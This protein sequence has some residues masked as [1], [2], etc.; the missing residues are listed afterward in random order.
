MPSCRRPRTTRLI[1]HYDDDDDNDDYDYY[2][3]DYCEQCHART[4]GTKGTPTTGRSAEHL[5]RR[6]GPPTIVPT[7]ITLLVAAVVGL[8]KQCSIVVAQS[9][10]VWGASMFSARARIGQQ[11]PPRGGKQRTSGAEPRRGNPREKTKPADE[12]AEDRATE[13][14]DRM[15]RRRSPDHNFCE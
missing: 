2:S 5:A 12:V 3:Y 4:A 7:H 9:C 11:M 13:G 1:Y 14:G 6:G 10:F 15:R 8:Q